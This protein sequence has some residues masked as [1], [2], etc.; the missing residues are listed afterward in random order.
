MSGSIMGCTRP[1]KCH[2]SCSFFYAEAAAFA[3]EG[4]TVDVLA[5]GQDKM[6][7]IQLVT[8]ACDQDPGTTPFISHL[9]KVSKVE[10]RL[11][12]THQAV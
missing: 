7:T 4:E 11:V 10:M 2:S 5:P 6:Q 3:A 1:Q 9:G 12:Q 8:S